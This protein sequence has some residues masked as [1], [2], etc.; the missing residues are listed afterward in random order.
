MNRTETAPLA[1]FFGA[2]GSAKHFEPLLADIAC[3]AGTLNFG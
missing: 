2:V 3:V 1:L